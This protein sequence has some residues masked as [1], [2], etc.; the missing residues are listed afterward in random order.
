M[1]ILVVTS[2]CLF[3]AVTSA[4]ENWP[5]FLGPEGR[6]TSLKSKV[7][8]RWS[9][10]ENLKWKAKINAGSS[11]PIVWGDR[12]FVTSYSG[13]GP[14]VSRTLHCL[15]RTDG[16]SVWDFKVDN[17]GTEDGMQGYITEHS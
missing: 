1:R 14:N 7:P 11:S 13:S 10:S 6:A 17:K 3:G 2:L 15:D 5:R 16:S 4:A 9:E 12:V 8:L